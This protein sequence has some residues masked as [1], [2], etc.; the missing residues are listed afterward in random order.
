MSLTIEDGTGVAGANSYASLVN[1]RAYATARGIALSATDSELE[2][3]AIKA[4][5]YIESFRTKFQGSKTDSAQSLQWPRSDVYI[6]GY[7]FESNLIPADLVN[8]Q[9]ACV[10][11]LHN[12]VDLMPTRKD[13]RE[14]IRDKTGPMETEWAPGSGSA[15]P[16]LPKV[17]ALL[18][19]LLKRVSFF[20][21]FRA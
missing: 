8:A 4:M 12:G 11:E 15:M 9:C 2:I 21:T 17:D 1:L 14:V 16:A 13:T 3:H 6:D 5:D 7:E 10:I 19:P 20:S 18:Q